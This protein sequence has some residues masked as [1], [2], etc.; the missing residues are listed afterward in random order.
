MR[1]PYIVL[2][3][4]AL[5]AMQANAAT[6]IIDSFTTTQSV[7]I[8]GG[9]SPPN[10]TADTGVVTGAASAG[11]A[12]NIMLTRTF[13]TG[14]DQSK[15]NS[16]AAPNPDILEFSVAANDLVNL[17]VLYDGGT[18]NVNS[19][20]LNLNLQ[21]AGSNPRFE[22]LSRSD[23][24]GT[25][26]LTIYSGT[27]NASASFNLPALGFGATPFTLSSIPYASFAGVNFA[28]VKAITL[29]IQGS[30]GLDA[31]LDILQA[32]TDDAPPGIPEPATLALTG[33]G[34]GALYLKR[35]RG[36]I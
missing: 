35:R 16:G 21:I 32:K 17:L 10:T 14:T 28:N 29:G 33:A 34:I 11:G 4:A 8:S 25:V 18:D 15:V 5:V 20:G 27:G 6:V 12:R 23:L 22:F 26:T 24:A 19:Q 36:L 13:G 3:G 1:I 7:T 30:S 2:A 9:S 31:Q